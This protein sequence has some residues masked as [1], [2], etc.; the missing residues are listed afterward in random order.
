MSHELYKPP[1]NCAS[2]PELILAVAV[3]G[4]EAAALAV[5]A[6]GAAEV[7]EPVAALPAAVALDVSHGRRVG[8]RLERLRVAG[9]AGIVAGDVTGGAAVHAGIAEAGD[10]GLLDARG[11]IGRAHV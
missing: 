10:E 11:E 4:F 2:Q 7:R 3:L 5:M 1:F 9:E 6:D 8:M